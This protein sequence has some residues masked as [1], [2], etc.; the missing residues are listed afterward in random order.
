MTDASVNITQLIDGR[1]LGGFQKMTALLCAAIIFVEGFNTQAPGYIAPALRQSWGL[2]P[3]DLGGFFA[4]GLFG[5]LL[6]AVFIA[7][8]ADRIGR[9]PL[10]LGCVPFLSVCAILTAFSTSLTMLD[11]ARFL[12]GLGIGGAMPN[13]VAL[14]SE[15]SPHHRRSLMVAVIFTGFVLGAVAVGL[16]S[17]WLVPEY[18]WEAVPLVGGIL[19]IVLTPVLFLTLPESVRFLVLR[20]KDDAEAQSLIRRLAPD[21]GPAPKRL[22]LGETPSGTISVM[23]L[24]RDGRAKRTVLLWIIYFMSLLDLFLLA[25]WLPTEMQA[26]GVSESVALIIG[27]LFQFGGVFGLIFGWLADRR[28]SSFALV[29]AF[30][31]GAV[32]VAAVGF[33]GANLPL[34]IVAVFGTGLGLIGGQSVTN[35]TAAIAYPTEIRSTGVGWATGIGRIGSIV[36]PSIAAYMHTVNV[37]IEYIFLAAAVPAL[38]AAVAAMGLSG[39]RT[40]IIAR[41][42]TA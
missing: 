14:T 18:G 26:L 11:I 17:T 3:A 10:L 7:P 6:G 22:I 34:V 40:S 37:A 24:F 42:A 35:A 23:A 2:G 36:G 25:N 16:S 12:T 5:L 33:A 38:C 15:Y 13:A 41:E 29:S 20:G 30:L 39:L 27:A 4:A 28:G 8:L 21:L 19:G 31:C 32:C 1:K 9:R